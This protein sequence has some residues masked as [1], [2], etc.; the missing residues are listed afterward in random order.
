MTTR[1]EI[2]AAASEYGFRL[3]AL[4]KVARL[5]GILHRLDR[6]DFTAGAWVLK[7]GTALN[8]FHLELPRLSV[9]VDVDFIGV[10][11]A[12]ALPDARER[13]EH[14]L[15]LCCERE[16][17]T[18]RRSPAEHAGGK[19]RLRFSSLLGGSQNLEIDV[20]YVWRVPLFEVERR[21]VRLPI[22]KGPREAP[23]LSL[24]ELAAGK[25][26]ALLSRAAPRDWFDAAE[27]LRLSPG[28][29]EGPRFRVAFVWQA[30]SS[31]QDFRQASLDP[32]GLTER[33]V[34]QQLLPVLR[35]G[36]ADRSARARAVTERLR[37]AVVPTVVR[38]CEWSAAEREFLDALLDHGRIEPALLSDDASL[39]RRVARQ[40]MLRWKQIHVRRRLGIAEEGGN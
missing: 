34:E 23:T 17:C 6:H 15:R 31:R 8:L 28:M 36:Q 22:V 29:I 9:D 16:G 14:G 10:E 3:D 7:G 4:E 30:A 25:F 21:K 39:Q 40:P 2:E 38:I 1:S 5:L 20:N 13:F 24:E 19:F 26:T 35:V 32:T 12:D 37:D 11:D 27:I 33:N 18:V